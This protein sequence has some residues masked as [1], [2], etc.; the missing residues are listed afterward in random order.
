MLPLKGSVTLVTRQGQNK[1]TVIDEITFA[2]PT[3][4]TYLW[5]EVSTNLAINT[6]NQIQNEDNATYTVAHLAAYNGYCGDNNKVTIATI[7][8]TNTAT[9]A[10]PIISSTVIIV[11]IATLYRTD[12]NTLTT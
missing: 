5:R 2:F 1:Y 10:F 8:A 7:D 11:Q 4:K 9:N 12:K 3:Y 6:T